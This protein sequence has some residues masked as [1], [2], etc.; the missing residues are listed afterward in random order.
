MAALAK[1][2]GALHVRMACPNC[3]KVLQLRNLS[4]KH[5]CKAPKTQ[6][7]MEARCSLKLKALQ[8]KAMNRLQQPGPPFALETPSTVKCAPGATME[9]RT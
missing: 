3:G 8:Q 4:Y 9:Q 7:Q 2:K 1:P 6:E 5:V